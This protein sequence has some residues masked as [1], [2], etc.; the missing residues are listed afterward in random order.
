MAMTGPA[1]IGPDELAFRLIDGT[2]ERKR[3]RT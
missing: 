1:L 2:A 3:K